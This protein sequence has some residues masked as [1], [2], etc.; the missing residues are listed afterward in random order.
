[1]NPHDFL[2]IDEQLTEEECAIGETVRA[3]VRTELAPHVSDW[4]E[5]G[6]VPADIARGLGKLGVLGIHLERYGCA[7]TSATAYGVA[8]RE[9]E[10]V[11][12]GLR[13]LEESL[14]YAMQ[15][16]QFGKPLAAF[17]LTQRKLADMTIAVNS[18]ALVAL[19][20]GRLK[21]AGKLTPVQVSFGKLANVRAALDVARTARGMLGAAGITLD[22][23]VMRHM[24]NLE[25][26]STYEGTEKMH[27]MR[28]GGELTGIPAF[29]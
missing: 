4:F 29:R 11:D 1:M 2:A 22:H 5:Q 8:C 27:S 17:Q 23:T 9:L 14:D 10:A 19:Q 3:Y 24:N 16:E 15:R 21:D 20:L 25:T 6:T 26:V 7:G 18:A 12:S 13:C 28:I